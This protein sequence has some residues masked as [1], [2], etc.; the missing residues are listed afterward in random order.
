MDDDV[1]PLVR[2]LL[3]EYEHV[4]REQSMRIRTRDHLF[5]ATLTA[6][7]AIITTM[8][9]TR[10][11]FELLLLLPPVAVILGWTYIAND[12]KISSIGSFIRFSLAPRISALLDPKISKS[13]GE[14][15]VFEWETAHRIDERRRGRKVIQL[16]IDLSAFVL[17]PFAGLVVFWIGASVTALSVIVSLIEAV[18]L[19]VI[20][21]Q[22]TTYADIRWRGD[23]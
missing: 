22:I 13:S 5:I 12:E 20:A 14:A 10:D 1:S 2:V 18:I 19:V 11:Q 9:S 17:L 15:N 16:V 7:A 21:T 6:A 4:K 3:T 23:S 8:V